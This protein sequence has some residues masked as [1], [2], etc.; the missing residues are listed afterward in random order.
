MHV[1]QRAARVHRIPPPTFVTIAKRPSFWDGMARDMDLIWVKQE[2]ENF[3]KWDWTGG[4]IL[5]RFNK[6]RHARKSER[7]GSYAS[8]KWR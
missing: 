6:F 2:A 7:A 4:I 8:R 5:I 3:L 1:R